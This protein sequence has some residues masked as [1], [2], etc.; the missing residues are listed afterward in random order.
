MDDTQRLTKYLASRE[1]RLNNL[2]KITDISGDVIT[3]KMNWAQKTLFDNMHYFNVILK[4]RQLGFSTFI[5]I[6]MLDSCLFNSN[7]S[8]GVIADTRENAEKLFNNKIKFAYENLPEWLKAE[9]VA[10]SDNARELAFSNG[11]VISVGTSFRGGTLQK[12]HISEYGK[13]AAKYP[14][15]AKEIKTGA[16]NAVHSGQQ[17]FV[18]ST[19]EG[20]QGEFFEV[21]ELSRKLQNEEAVL[22][23]LDP[24]LF[25]FPWYKNPINIMPDDMCA[26]VSLDKEDRQYFESLGVE[27]TPNQKAWYV[28]KK[29][30]QQEKMTQEHP[31]NYDEAFEASMEGAYYAK[32]MEIIRKNKQI[33]HIPYEPSQPVYTFWDIGIND[34]MAI[35]FFQDINMQY[36]FINYIE[37]TG[38]GWIYF[39]ELLKSLGYAYGRHYMPHDGGKRIMGGVVETGKQQAERFGITPIKIVP[40]TTNVQSDILNKCRPV[41]PR[42]WFD[43]VNCAK[44]IAYLDAYR[45]E[46][47]DKGGL[48]KDR[49]RHDESSHCADAFRTFAVGYDGRV[50]ETIQQMN[51]VV[52]PKVVDMD[53]NMFG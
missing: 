1:W 51:Y 37:A 15:K 28:K 35:W 6:Y 3:F 26:N 47:D 13:I 18:E 10:K 53:Y 27:L 12:L 39:S 16:L 5:L 36:R 41:L 46:W 2:Y 7:Q 33:A 43:K 40:R 20:K 42:C 50:E 29:A 23:P 52:Q 21:C 32:Q 9:R 49:P 24:K 11:S 31:S 45:K 4:A 48:W 34:Q 19:A 44:G 17:I 22:T 38:E 14:E 25:F 8:C 30:I